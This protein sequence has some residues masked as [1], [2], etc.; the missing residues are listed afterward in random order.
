MSIAIFPT[1]P[2]A[3]STAE[4]PTVAEIDRITAMSDLVLRNLLITQTYHLL[5]AA[6]ARRL[7]ECSNWC[8]FATWAS[9]QA[10]QT[11]RREDV[12]RL[13][14]QRL[15]ATPGFSK[16]L[17]DVIAAALPFGARIDPLGLRSSID[18]PVA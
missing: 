8:T 13:L 16:A 11:I 10:G 2:E 4:I 3:A 5:S 1:L 9:K 7:G 14:E 6:L 12:S 18:P 17:G 15:G